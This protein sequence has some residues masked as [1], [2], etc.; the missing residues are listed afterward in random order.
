[1]V[2]KDF[3]ATT[4]QAS[5]TVL[6]VWWVILGLFQ[7]QWLRDARQRL[8]VYDISLYFLLPGMMSLVSLLAVEVPELWR[9][10]FAAAGVVGA[11]ESVLLPIRRRPHGP[12][13]AFHHLADW[14]SFGLY[15]LIS[16]VALWPGSVARIGIGLQPLQVEGTLIAG[17]L[18]LGFTLIWTMFV[19]AASASGVARREPPSA[20][21]IPQPAATSSRRRSA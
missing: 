14:L 15:A 19:S 5:F 17:L 1:M 21:T 13:R 9:V 20:V 4:A 8:A 3:Y 16:L 10:T 11:V 6:S 2:L 7:Q 12:S 18:V